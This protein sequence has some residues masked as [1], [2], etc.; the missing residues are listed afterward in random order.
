LITPK[1]PRRNEILLDFVLVFLLTAAL[2]RP[3]FKAKYTD[4][5]AS[6]ESTFIADAR[7]LVDHWPHPQWQPLWYGGTRFDYIYPPGLRYGTALIAKT[8]GYLPVKAY[9]AYTALFY[10]VGIAGV[11]L[12]IR[13]GT[14]SRRAAWLGAAA[15]ALLSPSF[16]FLKDMRQDS[17]MWMPLRLGVLVKYGE[18]PHMTA[19]ALIP[20]ALAF[21]W[22]ALEA[23]RPAALAAAALFSAA[24]ASNN[25]Y[26]ATA[27][28]VFYPILVWSFWITRPADQSQRILAPALAI[29]VLAYGLTAFW[30]VPSYFKVTAENMK[31]VSEHGTTWSIW[32]GAIV[33]IAFALAT[34]RWARGK[35][36]R[37]WAVFT[38]GSAVFFSLNVLGNNFFNFRIAGEPSRLAPELDLVYVLGAVTI[39]LWLWDLPGR[40]PRRITV[41]VLVAAFATSAGY[42]RHAWHMF[43]LWPDYQNRIEYKVSEWLWKN[44]PDSRAYPTGSVRF[45]FNAWHDLPQLGGGSDQGVLNGVVVNAQ[46]ELNLGP[47]AEPAILWMQS[48]GVDTT[49]VSDKRSQEVFKDYL[50]PEKL[51]GAL[52]S[53][54]DDHQGNIIYRVPRRYAARVR[55]VETS[56][57]QALKPPQGNTD[58]DNLRAYVDVVE[59]G[60]DAP[61]TLTRHGTDT[62]VVRAKVEPGQSIVVQESYDPAWQAW[63]DGKP[64][65]IRKD[66]VGFMAL[67][68][69]PGQQ[70]IQ[71]MFVTP[72]ENHMGQAVTAVSLLAV[73]ALFAMGFRARQRA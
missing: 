39:F 19:L 27:L 66:P 15:T 60:P 53:I 65:A 34:D 18:G 10:A 24:V 5:W 12:L 13:V 49:Y 38:G 42:V 22:L 71:L 57:L 73:L 61:A 56:R 37:T 67:E 7:F 68:A 72:F 54:Y 59:K 47:K 33:A 32:I 41:I 43:P 16:L 11:Y 70:E 23:R 35:P 55:V 36:Q 17:W 48:M 40:W 4:K 64:L 1:L 6:I 58:V 14:R 62:M 9:H 52:P 51:A 46:W 29:P 28:A 26:G 8:F 30:L 63:S 69:P 21:T 31:Y 3:F 44:M 2:I 50:Y 25:F 20:L 45:W